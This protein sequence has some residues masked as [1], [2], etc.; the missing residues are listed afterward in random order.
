[1]RRPIAPTAGHY[2]L[3]SVLIGT[4][5]AFAILVGALALDEFRHQRENR[6][7][8]QLAFTVTKSD[9]ADLKRDLQAYA[10]AQ[11]PTDAEIADA[12]VYRLKVCLRTPACHGRIVRLINRVVRVTNNRIV[13][14]PDTMPPLPAALAPAD[15]TTVVQGRPVPGPRGAPG[16]DGRDGKPGRD[17]IPG[18][19]V[20]GLVDRIA[21]AETKLQNVVARVDVLDRLVTGLCRLLTPSKC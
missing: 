21:S 9:V 1:M 5:G 11:A 6:V 2:V 17:A 18:D 16:K 12:V 7:A 4:V 10:R 8:D 15:R 20:P 14:A 3:V 19:L 13:Q